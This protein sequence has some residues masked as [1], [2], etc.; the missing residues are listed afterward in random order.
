MNTLIQSSVFSD[1]LL[2]LSDDVAKAHILRR[3]ASAELGN[4]GDCEPVGEGVSEMRV[5]FGPGY[6]VYF[7]RRGGAIYVLLCGGSKA[8][9]KRDIKRA[10]VMAQ[11][12]KGNTQ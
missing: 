4:F 11:H 3:I 2:S 9:Q 6:R 1:W 12:L 5:H 8:S 10:K 7:I